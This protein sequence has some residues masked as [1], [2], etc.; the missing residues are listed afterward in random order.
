VFERGPG[1][2]DFEIASFKLV[3]V[4][5]KDFFW[6]PTEMLHH[7]QRQDINSKWKAYSNTR[8]L[9]LSLS[10]SLSLSLVLP[11]QT[12]RRVEAHPFSSHFYFF[13]VFL[14]GNPQH[15]PTTTISK[16]NPPSPPFST[17]LSIQSLLTSLKFISSRSL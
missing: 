9:T 12:H 17:L 1:R 10:L 16:S 2:R 8:A 7:Y 4:R 14:S 11:A 5:L 13:V 15:T 6:L 3:S